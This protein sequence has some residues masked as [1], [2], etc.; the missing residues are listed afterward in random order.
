DNPTL[1]VNEQY[2]FFNPKAGLT[3][4]ANDWT[5]FGSYSVGNKEPN[6]DDFEAAAT[7]LP[8]PERLHDVDFGFEKRDRNYNAGATL[9]Y[10]KYTNQLVLTGKINDVGAY[11]RTNIDD[12]YRLGIELQAGTVLTRWARASAN[13]TLSR[14][15]VKNFQEYIDDY[16]NGGQKINRYAETDISFS[17]AVT[18]AATITLTPIQKFSIDLLSRYVG[19]QYL[20]N[21]S[22][23]AR[24]LNAFYT[25]DIRA[26]YSFSKAWIKNTDLILQVNNVFNK[27]YEPN[28]YTF[29]Y[30]YGNELT[31]S[32]YYFPMAGIN[33]M[34][35]LNVRL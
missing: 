16:D 6:R 8:K 4:T 32:N 33:W 12:S 31:T 26:I 27:K 18:G 28:G 14:N 24:K 34:V 11:T 30:Y 15:K 22:N 35:G 9:Y 5:I 17:P 19:K 23:E 10:M 1:K 13:L 2:R 25:Q 29:S 3:Y 7:Q 21:T 20:D